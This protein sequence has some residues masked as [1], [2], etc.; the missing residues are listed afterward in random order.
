MRASA[1]ARP[2]DPDAE[3]ERQTR[4]GDPVQIVV[5]DRVEHHNPR[6]GRDCFRDGLVLDVHASLHPLC[7]KVSGDFDRR[8]IR[9]A[10]DTQASRFYHAIHPWKS[11]AD[12]GG[13]VTEGCEGRRDFHADMAA[14][15]GIDLFEEDRR[16][17]N[18][19]TGGC[20]R[21]RVPRS[22]GFEVPAVRTNGDDGRVREF[23]A[24]RN[25]HHRRA[26]A[27]REMDGG[28]AGT[29]QVVCNEKT[30]ERCH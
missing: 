3:I 12:H 18:R 25:R 9:A 1:D 19:Q 15:R 20:G 27:H 28:I 6:A 4:G 23:G 10:G 13:I 21:D 30:V 14:Q 7:A 26:P 5:A 11:G 17:T 29:R 16:R 24:N 2:A 8:K 22:R